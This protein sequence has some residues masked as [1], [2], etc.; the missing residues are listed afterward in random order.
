MV[1]AIVSLYNGKFFLES[2]LNDLVKQTLYSKDKLEIIIIDSSSTG[3]PEDIILDFQNRYK[4][5]HYI[6]TSERETLYKAWNRGILYSS[7]KYITNANVDDIHRNDALVIQ[8]NFLE[9][10]PDIDLVYHCHYLSKILNKSYEYYISEKK[11]T[12]P[13]FDN[14]TVY[15]FYPFCHQ[16]MWRKSIHQK[17]GLFD[18]NYSIAGDLDFAFKFSIF[19]LK[20]KLINEFLGVQISRDDQL[21]L[22]NK[23]TSE[24]NIIYKKYFNREYILLLYK[25]LNIFNKEEN[26]EYNSMKDLFYLFFEYKLPGQDYYIMNYTNAASILN[27]LYKYSKDNKLVEDYLN[28]LLKYLHLYNHKELI[29]FLESTLDIEIKNIILNGI[30]KCLKNLK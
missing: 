10:N 26:F 6:R 11:I 27:V 4:N 22:N 2:C 24:F 7:G 12:Y 20:A 19:G 17:I 29:N 28:N 21:V 3:H 18:E 25:N 9:K 23:F 1:S 30:L 15:L 13:D 5:I 16:N 8:M 14:R